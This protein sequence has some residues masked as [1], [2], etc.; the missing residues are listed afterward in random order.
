M[1]AAKHAKT[2]PSNDPDLL[3]KHKEDLKFLNLYKDNQVV[4][5]DTV[6]RKLFIFV[7]AL[8]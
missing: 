2:L 1:I 5:V 8:N 4:S 6:N 3:P 7:L